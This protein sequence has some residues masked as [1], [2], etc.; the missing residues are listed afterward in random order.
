MGWNQKNLSFLSFLQFYDYYET[1]VFW[2]VHIKI[3]ESTRENIV[4]WEWNAN[5]LLQ[6]WFHPI[7]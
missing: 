4:A 1:F 7:V 5:N 3:K 6:K 2:L